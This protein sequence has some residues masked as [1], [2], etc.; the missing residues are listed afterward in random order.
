MVL[1]SIIRTHGCECWTLKKSDESRIE[2][3]EMK[4]LRQILR[5]SWTARK[6][7]ELVSGQSWKAGAK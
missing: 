5:V 4:G 3:F 2:A 6:T 7:N 1:T